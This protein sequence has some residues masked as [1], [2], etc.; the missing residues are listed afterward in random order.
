MKATISLKNARGS[1]DAVSSKSDAHRCILAAALSDA[2]TKILLNSTSD[3]IKAAC[4]C[5]KSLGG[6]ISVSGTDILVTP[7]KNIPEKAVFDCGESGNTIRFFMPAAAALGIEST[8]TGRGRLPQRPQGPLLEALR[9]NGAACSEDGEFPIKISG[10]L[11]SGV[12]TLPG[13]VSSQYVTGLLFALPLL[14]GDS[15]IKLIPPV[16]SKPYIDMTVSTLKK[17]GVGVVS[18]E[19]SYFVKGNQKYTSPKEIKVDGDWSNGAFF[20]CLGALSSVTVN[21]LFKNSIQGDKAICDIVRSMGASV[22]KGEDFVKV[23]KNALNG[24][25]INARD[26]P[27]LIPVVSSL[28]TYAKGATIIK[29]AER[30]RLKESDRL[31]S[32]TSLINEA[33]GDVNEL[34]DGL[35]IV[36]G[37]KLKEKFT[38]S[39]FGDH[40]MVMAAALLSYRSEVVIDDFESVNKTYPAFKDDLIKLGGTVEIS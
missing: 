29:N 4:S 20:V 7:P 21:G 15:Q 3:D 24:I 34:P 8:F 35:F 14:D 37:K 32:I 12:F 18:S 28:A 11:K 33:G 13:N 6:E 16:E 31:K 2:P 19:N 40:R 10:K 22:M 27:D 39:S 26:I 36:G 25:T 1:I 17:F 9:E 5:V 30:L 38:I 23:Q